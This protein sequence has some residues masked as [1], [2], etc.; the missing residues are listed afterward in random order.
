MKYRF[1]GKE[2]RLDF[3]MYPDISL[4]MAGESASKARKLRQDNHDPGEVR[5]EQ[6]D[7]VIRD[8]RNSLE[9]VARDWIDHQSAR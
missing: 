3:G 2:K 6:K 1:A 5:K 7:R 8:N 9:A 4:K